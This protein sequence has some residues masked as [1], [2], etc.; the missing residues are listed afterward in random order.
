MRFE[1]F[2]VGTIRVASTDL[3]QLGRYEEDCASKGPQGKK[4]ITILTASTLIS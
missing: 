2:S 1:A 3:E 4:E